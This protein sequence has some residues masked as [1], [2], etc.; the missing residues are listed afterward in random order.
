MAGLTISGAAAQGLEG[1]SFTGT[2]D[3]KVQEFLVP[4]ESLEDVEYNVFE[5]PEAM[6]EAFGRQHDAV[7]KAAAQALGAGGAGRITLQSLI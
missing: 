4:K 7:A 5:T 3:G 2:L 1:V 6:L